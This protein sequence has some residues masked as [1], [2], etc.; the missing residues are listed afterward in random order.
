VP[1]LPDVEG[2]LV[3]LARLL[4]GQLVRDVRV[5][6]AGVLR[7]A[8]PPAFADRLIGRWFAHPDRRGKWLI[9]PTDGPS[10]LVHN[11]MTGR[12]YFVGFGHHTEADRHDRIV[13]ADALEISLPEMAET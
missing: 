2:Y 10:V 8:T 4:P 6:D 3:T 12:P 11:G 7:N 13:I 5:L 9:F 1:E